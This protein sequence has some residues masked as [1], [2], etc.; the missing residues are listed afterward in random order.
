MAD[1]MSRGMKGVVAGLA[2]VG[3]AGAFFSAYTLHRKPGAVA[4]VKVIT[5]GEEVDLA[6]HRA[7]GKY[8]VFDF[9]AVWCPPCRVLGPALERLAARRPERLAIRKVDIVDWTMPVAAQYHVESLPYLVLF[10]DQGRRLAEGEAVFAALDRV[11]GEEASEV[12]Q[13]TGVEP[14][15][16]PAATAAPAASAGATASGH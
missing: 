15:P 7:P 6:A 14:Q 12:S 4:D 2:V 9:Y 10:D 5:H 3:A 1:G 13:I 16:N 8:T 11:F